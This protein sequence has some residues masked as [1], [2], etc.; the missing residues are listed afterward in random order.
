[1][2]A[3]SDA[4][5]VQA[6]V[7]DGYDEQA[8]Q[9]RNNAEPCRGPEVAR[10]GEDRI[11]LDWRTLADGGR[12]APYEIERRESSEG[13]RLDAVAEWDHYAA[14]ETAG[15]GIRYN[16]GLPQGDEKWLLRILP[17]R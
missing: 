6:A 11:L 4:R 5:P 12:V 3:T 14:Q 7:E 8:G 17:N 15:N 1:M 9:A 13:A 10:E 2:D 16:R